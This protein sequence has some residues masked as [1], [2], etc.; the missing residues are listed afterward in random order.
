METAKAPPQCRQAVFARCADHLSGALSQPPR[1]G[2]KAGEATAS[3]A[4]VQSPDF[5]DL[6]IVSAGL[7]PTAPG[8]VRFKLAKG[9]V[10]LVQVVCD[11]DNL[12]IGDAHELV[13]VQR[14]WI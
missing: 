3:V 11:N 7:N 10:H 9:T 6:A 5:H 1:P 14:L 12:P 8:R 13:G 2:G 4:S